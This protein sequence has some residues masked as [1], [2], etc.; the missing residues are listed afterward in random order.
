MD[1]MRMKQRQEPEVFYYDYA[2]PLG[3]LRIEENGR[4]LTAVSP[5]KPVITSVVSA[6]SSN[7]SRSMAQA[8]RNSPLV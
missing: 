1:E 8:V 5:G 2:T 3:M 4:G 6:Q 7:A